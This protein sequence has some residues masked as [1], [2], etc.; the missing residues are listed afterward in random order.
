M[1]ERPCSK[2]GSPLHK[3]NIKVIRKPGK[4]PTRI[5]RRCPPNK[6]FVLKMPKRSGLSMTAAVTSPI[7][8]QDCDAAKECSAQV[9]GRGK[10]LRF[11][12]WKNPP[13]S[14]EGTHASGRLAHQEGTGGPVT[15]EGVFNY[16]PPPRFR[17]FITQDQAAKLKRASDR[18]ISRFGVTVEIL[19]IPADQVEADPERFAELVPVE[20]N[21]QGG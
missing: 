15:V 16:S 12:A 10:C 4:R 11:P 21:I 18:P 7:I 14:L 6:T 19:T 3:G 1:N 9:P 8:C 13:I 20:V 5:C 2:C 17:Y